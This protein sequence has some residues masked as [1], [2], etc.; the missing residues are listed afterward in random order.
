MVE[1]IVPSILLVDENN[2]L[3]HDDDESDSDTE[4]KSESSESVENIEIE[5]NSLSE[6]GK[7]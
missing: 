2:A 5:D 4:R 6:K 3:E 7:N 1:A